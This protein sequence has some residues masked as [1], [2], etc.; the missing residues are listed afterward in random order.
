MPVELVTR[1]VVVPV[2][3]LEPYTQLETHPV[4]RQVLVPVTRMGRFPPT[5]LE[6]VPGFTAE[7]FPVTR[8]V[9]VTR[10]AL[11]PVTQPEF[12]PL[13]LVQDYCDWFGRYC[14]SRCVGYY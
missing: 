13:P 1:P 9:P 2:T 12:V 8:P 11:A 14:G 3:Q 7:T 4:P 5:M 10:P 6:H